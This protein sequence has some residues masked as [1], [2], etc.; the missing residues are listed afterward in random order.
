MILLDTTTP[1]KYGIDAVE[2]V[3]DSCH[4]IMNYGVDRYKR[5]YPLSLDEEQKRQKERHERIWSCVGFH[6]G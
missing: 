1:S 6:E 5:P 2:D 4:A 3:L